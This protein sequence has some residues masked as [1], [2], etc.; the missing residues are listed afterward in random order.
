[1]VVQLP[2][3][4]VNEI[5]SFVPKDNTMKS[6]VSDLLKPYI[7][8]YN[9]DRQIN[10]YYSFDDYMI[11]YHEFDDNIDT[12]PPSYRDIRDIYEDINDEY[13]GTE[14]SIQ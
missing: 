13:E 7:V 12:S 6:P 11:N 4:L 9:N 10:K 3:D 1:M 14:C 2:L 5:L 8:R